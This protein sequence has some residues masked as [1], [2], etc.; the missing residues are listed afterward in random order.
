MNFNPILKQQIKDILGTD[1]YH[2]NG[3]LNR[4]QVSSIVFKNPK[5]LKALNELV[6]PAVQIDGIKWFNELPEKYPYAIKEAALLYES[7]SYQTLDKII[8][9]HVDNDIRI[10]RVM[11]RDG[12][13]REQV[14]ERLNNQMPQHKKMK[15][16]DF[17]LDN[18][19]RKNLKKQIDLLHL[20]LITLSK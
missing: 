13:S 8:V 20:K 7:K 5:L 1:A 12:I 9:V 6:H 15:M 2:N 17:L 14:L 3:R 10:Q 18:V 4:R 16:A 19:S 11:Q